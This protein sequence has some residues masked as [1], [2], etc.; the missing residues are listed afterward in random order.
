MDAPPILLQGSRLVKS[1]AL[2]RTNVP[3]YCGLPSLSHQ[4]PDIPVVEVVVTLVVVVVEVVETGATVV[5][6]VVVLEAVVVLVVVD[7]PQDAKTID[8][9][10]RRVMTSQKVPF[11]ISPH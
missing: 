3:P 10:M 7:V 9:T 5:V 4:L 8:A 1:K 6:W 11:F 2:E